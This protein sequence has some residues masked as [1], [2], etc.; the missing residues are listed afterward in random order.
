MKI[1]TLSLLLALIGA[2]AWANDNVQ[3]FDVIIKDHKFSPEV[4]EVKAGTKFTL[5]VK[6]MDATEEEFESHELNREKI[7]KGG[8][9][10]KFNLGPLT[11]G[12]YNFFGEFNPKTAQGKIIVK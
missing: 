12:E 9:S 1:S 7:I 2:P 4:V 5:T 10:K 11:A 8:D 3:N 6:N